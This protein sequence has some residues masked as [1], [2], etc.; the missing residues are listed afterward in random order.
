MATIHI[1]VHRTADAGFSSRK[2]HAAAVKRRADLK[3]AIA[4]FK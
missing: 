4:K 2:L 3:S 1:H